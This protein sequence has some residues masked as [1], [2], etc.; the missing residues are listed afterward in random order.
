MMELFLA[1]IILGLCFYLFWRT[2]SIWRLNQVR[3]KGLYPH[4][5]KPTMFDVRRLLIE[6][7]KESA[8]RV[9]GEIFHSSYKD[10]QKA[11][12]EL[13]RSIREKAH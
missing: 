5:G 13:E 9:Y 12:D 4:Q 10:A 8:I 11:V 6:G 7:E 2:S 1:S 3:R